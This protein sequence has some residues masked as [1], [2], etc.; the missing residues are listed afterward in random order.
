M[1]CRQTRI[2][3]VKFIGIIRPKIARRLH[4]GKQHL[5]IAI[6]QPGDNGLQ[7]VIACLRIKATQ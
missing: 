1:L 7:I 3:P 5:N 6:L 4:P 2:D